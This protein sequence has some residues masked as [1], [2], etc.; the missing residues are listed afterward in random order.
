M[1]SNGM[2]YYLYGQRFGSRCCLTGLGNTWPAWEIDFCRHLVAGELPAA[3]RIVRE[4]DLPYLQ[5]TGG[6][7]RYWAAVKALMEMAGL[8]GGPMRAPLK[9]CTAT[10]RQQLREV[11]T[12]I[13][14]L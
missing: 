8:P 3:E 14:L 9:A 12:R 2:G 1:G 13:G 5:V 11:C 7:G 4:K 10:Q 6:T